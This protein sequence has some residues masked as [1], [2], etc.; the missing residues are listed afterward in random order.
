MHRGRHVIPQSDYIHQCHI[1]GTANYPMSYVQS[2][3][4]RCRACALIESKEAE[5]DA[6][7]RA[8]PARVLLVQLERRVQTLHVLAPRVRDHH[9]ASDRP[10]VHHQRNAM[11]ATGGPW[12]DEEPLHV[13]GMDLVPRA[14]REERGELPERYR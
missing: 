4:K 6:R 2:Q 12:L 14:K 9:L 11:A 10:R 5:P 3:P 1:Y 8:E 7:V 13:V